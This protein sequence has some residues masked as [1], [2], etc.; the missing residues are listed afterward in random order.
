[1]ISIPLAILSSLVVLYFLGETINTLTLGGLAWQS[2]SW[3]T[4]SRSPSR[5]PIAC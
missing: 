2:A 1:M 4:T 5:I 3:S